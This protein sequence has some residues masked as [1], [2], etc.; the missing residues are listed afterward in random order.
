[1]NLNTKKK[2]VRFVSSISSLVN[3]WTYQGFFLVAFKSYTFDSWFIYN[4]WVG[5]CY[6]YTFDS[7]FIYKR[8]IGVFY[9][10]LILVFL[11]KYSNIV[12]WVSKRVC[13]GSHQCG[14]WLVSLSCKMKKFMGCESNPKSMKIFSAKSPT[15]I[16]R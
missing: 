14:S 8:W 12:W 1:M 3:L 11:G 2:N 16:V 9:Q 7:S 15:Y 4:H 13:W 6:L 10:I 5:V